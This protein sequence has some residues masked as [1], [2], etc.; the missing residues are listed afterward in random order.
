MDTDISMPSIIWMHSNSKGGGHA[1]SQWRHPGAV[2][3]MQAK[4]II[5]YYYSFIIDYIF[6]D[7]PYLTN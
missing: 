7:E 5:R 4:L 3:G 6:T 2:I 1:D